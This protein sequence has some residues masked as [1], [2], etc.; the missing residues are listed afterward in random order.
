V[1]DSIADIGLQKFHVE[2]TPSAGKVFYPF[3]A[4]SVLA[5][6]SNEGAEGTVVGWGVTNLTQ[7]GG[8]PGS[9]IFPVFSERLKQIREDVVPSADCQDFLDYVA[10][11]H[12]PFRFHPGVLCAT[13]PHKSIISGEPEGICLGDSG[14]PLVVKKDGGVDVIIGLVSDTWSLNFDSACGNGL[15]V[16]T[17]LTREYIRWVQQVVFGFPKS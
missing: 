16:F 2:I 11:G 5:C 6:A 4:N 9:G 10:F 14:G 13:P 1:S 7:I 8:S 17:V 12:F 3:V 15:D